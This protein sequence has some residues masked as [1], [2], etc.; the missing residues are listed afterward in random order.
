M[1]FIGDIVDSEE[2]ADTFLVTK[3][4]TDV[5]TGLA[6]DTVST[7]LEWEGVVIPS[8]TSLQYGA[9]GTRHAAS[10][11]IYSRHTLVG[12]Y[13][14]DDSTSRKPDIVTWRNA[15]YIVNVTE[16]FSHF[17]YHHSVA[18]LMQINPPQAEG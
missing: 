13:K 1:I 15:M 12:G 10:I 9:D 17:G 5:S 3:T 14:I 8:K 7:P 11:D 2:F 6:R 18:D 4:T 16:D